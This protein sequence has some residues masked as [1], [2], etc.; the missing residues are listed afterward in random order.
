[1]HVFIH[2]FKRLACVRTAWVNHQKFCEWNFSSF[3]ENLFKMLIQRTRCMWCFAFVNL[4]W[5]HLLRTQERNQ[6]THFNSRESL[7]KI[8]SVERSKSSLSNTQFC[9]VRYIVN[10]E[11]SFYLSVKK[12]R[13]ISYTQK[14]NT[15]HSTFCNDKM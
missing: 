7:F 15:L 6:R 4:I 5:M 1:M 10:S 2:V 9:I 11:K 14:L 3:P 8:T 12:Q 13:E